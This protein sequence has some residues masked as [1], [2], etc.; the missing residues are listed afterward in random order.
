MSFLTP[1]WLL[2]LIPLP[3]YFWKRRSQMWHTQIGLWIVY[4]LVILALARPVVSQKPIT[5]EEAG[6]D[7]IFAVDLSYSMR[8][9]D[10]SPSRLDAAKKLLTA[11]VRSNQRDRFGVIGF[12]TSA[13]VLSPLTKDTELLEHLFGG[14]DE[15][16]IITKGTDIMSALELSRKMSHAEKPTVILLTDGGDERSY[17]KEADFIR[18]HNLAVSVVM[19][20]SGEG[21]TLPSDGGILKDD[22]GHIVIS[23]RN[24]AIEEIVNGGRV[25]EGADIGALRSLINDS[26]HEDFSGSTSVMRYQEWFYLPLSIAL[27]VFIVTFTTIGKKISRKILLLGG[28]IGL[29]A[30]GGVL[31]FGY[32]YLAKS[33]YEKGHFERAAEL[34]REVDDPRARYNRASSLYKAGKIK[35]ALD[36]YRSLRSDDP[37]FKADIFYNIGNCYIRLQEFESA[38]E[39]LLKSLTLRYSR[40]ADQNLRAIVGVEEQQT[41][42]VRKEKKDQFTHDENKPTGESKPS[43]A[44]GGSNMKS[45]MASGGGGDDGKKAESDP[46]LS[47]AQGKAA[48]SSRQYELINQRSIHETK[49]W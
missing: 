17:Q 35:E 44:G 19:L 4:T 27:I 41:L 39:A 21:S 40:R 10:I 38:R 22:Q 8:A 7:V 28:L 2:G 31:D 32:L 15:S 25:I 46:R 5:V 43:K 47:M 36:L 13:I 33:N 30:N 42:N 24:D 23:S 12:T 9:G 34:Y 14:L 45:D 26:V 3:A 49:P 18:E 48:L 37:H 1:F 29:S 20:A 6:S 11:S 16:Q